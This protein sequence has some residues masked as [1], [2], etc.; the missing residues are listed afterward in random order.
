MLKEKL[1]PDGVGRVAW[2]AK[3][4]DVS[5]GTVGNSS[6]VIVCGAVNRTVQYTLVVVVVGLVTV[7]GLSAYDDVW[8]ELERER[9]RQ[10]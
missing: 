9:S 6:R 2:A 3:C 1:L 5:Q 8:E 4:G 10:G 7:D